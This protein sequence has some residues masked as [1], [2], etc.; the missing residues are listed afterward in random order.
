M[1]WAATSLVNVEDPTRWFTELAEKIFAAG[2]PLARFRIH[3]DILHPQYAG[4]STRWRRGDPRVEI[5]R[6]THEFLE[7]DCYAA[8][9]V[10]L[11][12]EGTVPEIRRSLEVA[13]RELDFPVVKE[14][15]AE[16]LTDYLALPLRL[17]NG[18]TGAASFATDRAGGFT[19]YEIERLRQVTRA[20]ARGFE[21]V[22]RHETSR[23]LARAYLGHR[24]GDRVL[25]GAVR[26]GDGETIDAVIW[27]SDLRRSTALS[28]EMPAGDFLALLNQ[29]FDCLA[30]AVQEQGG[31]ILRFIGDAVLAIFPVDPGG[32]S[33]WAEACARAVRATRL[34]EANVERLNGERAGKGRDPIAYGIGLHLSSVHYGN[35]GTADRVEFTVVG[36]A[37]NE[38]AKIEAQCKVLGE[39]VLISDAVARCLAE[40]CRDLGEREI[41]GVGREMRL[42]ALS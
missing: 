20:A 2:L 39:K 8:S 27:F 38:A 33:G 10:Y 36:A 15:K 30:G 14:L 1:E 6:A 12:D 23:S 9:P 35:I 41:P 29:Y 7:G 28:A 26:R 22:I 17:A 37:A 19:A 4:M 24:T 18:R 13:D 25:A 42:F 32:D 34:A 16:G 3:Y 11:L 40:T 5:S 31:E 21:I